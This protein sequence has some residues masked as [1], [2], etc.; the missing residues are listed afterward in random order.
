MGMDVC[1]RQPTADAGE[2]FRANVWA[3]RPIHDL[4]GRLCSDL[5]DPALM[6]AELDGRSGDGLL[7]AYR[8]DTEL[9][10]EWIEFL[11]HC[12]GFEVW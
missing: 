11:R 4:I 2:C 3:W 9:L 5:L 8:V 7:S 10:R 6:G 12:G 1:G